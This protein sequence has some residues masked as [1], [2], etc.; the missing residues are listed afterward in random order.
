LVLATGGECLSVTGCTAL[1]GVW[2]DAYRE[3]EGQLKEENKMPGIVVG[4][5]GSDHS[6]RA[7]DWAMSEAAVRHAPLTVLTVQQATAGYWGFAPSPYMPDP[8]LPGQA[9]KEATDETGIALGRLGT[10]ERPASVT[11]RTVT[12]LPAEEI[13]RAG[14]DADM[15][16]VG[17]HGAGEFRELLTRSVSSRVSHHARCP[18]VVIR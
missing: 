17:S 10:G 6:C 14:Q 1:T 16:V 3:D 15:I 11:V 5:D 9:A 2:G 7:L 12:G 13:L 8:D 18:V 4:V